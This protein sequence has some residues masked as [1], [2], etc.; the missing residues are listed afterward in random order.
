MLPLA[1]PDSP[2]DPTASR[3]ARAGPPTLSLPPAQ[4]LARYELPR[5]AKREIEARKTE[6]ESA[7]DADERTVRRELLARHLSVNDAA[8]VFPG[9]DARASAFPGVLRG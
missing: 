2:P 3:R 5:E 1:S 4:L 9:C 6:L 8:C 7:S